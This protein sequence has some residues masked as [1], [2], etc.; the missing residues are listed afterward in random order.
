M[1][2]VNLRLVSLFKTL[3]QLVT[4]FDNSVQR[5]LGGNELLERFEKANKS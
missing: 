4:A 1:Q 5:F 2:C 3:Q